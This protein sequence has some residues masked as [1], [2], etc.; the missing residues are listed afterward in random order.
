M[1]KINIVL[2]M[3]MVSLMLAPQETVDL[4]IW[5][6]QSNAQGY[7]GDA[8]EYPKD[9]DEL[10]KDILLN[11]TVFGKESSHGKWISMQPQ[12]GRYP[13]GHF[14]PEV[15]FAR[16]LKKGGYHPAIFKYTQGGTG[17]ARDW[18]A[19]GEGGIYDSMV[20][21]L[22]TAIQQLEDSGHTV[23]IQGFVWIQGETDAGDDKAA[24]GYEE[25]LRT[26]L[27]HLR[28][29]VL[30]K[31]DLK[32]ILGVDEQHYFLKERPIVLEAQKKIAQKDVNVIYTTMYGLPKADET[33]LTPSG[34]VEHGHRIYAAYK[35]VA[36]T[37]QFS[38]SEPTL[39]S[40]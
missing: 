14:G 38:S 13:A 33:H 6:G 16:E 12:K 37:T 5:A 19:P 25:N 9:G 3:F 4:F 26:L 22:K 18:K 15:S 29:K 40:Q 35:I 20:V 31:D 23:N 34:L 32:V 27:T 28:T 21:H 10:D 2:I 24:N 11:Y 39:R 8:K 7:T 1:K 30:K 36:N 17:L